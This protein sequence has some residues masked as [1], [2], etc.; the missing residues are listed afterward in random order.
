[1]QR[2]EAL[3]AAEHASSR[4]A[5]VGRE[6]L[7]RDVERGLDAA[8]ERA[9][10]IVDDGALRFIADVAWDGFVGAVRDVLGERFGNR[11]RSSN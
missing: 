4:V 7:N 9:A 11:H 10:Q 5:G 6:R 3:G 1:M 8:A 2:V